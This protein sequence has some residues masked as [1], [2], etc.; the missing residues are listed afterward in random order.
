MGHRAE[1]CFPEESLAAKGVILWL[2][3]HCFARWRRGMESF[4]PQIGHPEGDIKFCGQVLLAV[5]A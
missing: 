4:A 3:V 1:W 2:A 5:G